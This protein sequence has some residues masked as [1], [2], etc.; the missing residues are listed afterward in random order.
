MTSPLTP[1]FGKPIRQAAT[2]G[3]RPGGGSNAYVGARVMA[4]LLTPAA[5]AASL[6]LYNAGSASDPLL[7]VAAAASGS[8]VYI[9]LSEVGGTPFDVDIWC[10][11]T[12]AGAIVEL[13]LDKS[14]L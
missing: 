5:A 1:L 6:I 8:S 13:W 4:V 3:V 14:Q 7:D 10:V 2:A 11:L 9:D 12:G